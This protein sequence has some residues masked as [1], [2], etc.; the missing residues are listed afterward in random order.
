MLGAMAD[1]Q[2]AG[3]PATDAGGQPPSVRPIAP[4]PADRFDDASLEDPRTYRAFVESLT[5]RIEGRLCTKLDD[6]I[7]AEIA[8]L[9]R[10]L[11]EMPPNAVAAN[12]VYF[13]MAFDILAAE[14]PNLLLARSIRF[15]LA[16]ANDRSARGITRWISFISGSTPLNAALSAVVSTFILALLF[17]LLIVS[18]HQA[19]ARAIAGTSALLGSLDDGSIA[20]LLIAIHAAFIGGIVSILARIQDFLAVH[21]VSPPLIY[22]SIVRKPFLAATLVVLVFSVLRG[23]LISLHGVDLT[24]PAAP[25]LAWAIGFLCG[26]SE[27]FAA[28]FVVS[29]GS[30]LGDPGTPAAP[31]NRS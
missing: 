11:A 2:Q 27:R 6:N 1:L 7:Q 10:L 20:I 9:L 17:L 14:Q 19:I 24:G 26:F 4:D 15:E 18:G 23:G 22:I 25:Y 30:R 13:E 29:A 21:A 5:D 31:Q 28:D 16:A 12:R 8:D 3:I